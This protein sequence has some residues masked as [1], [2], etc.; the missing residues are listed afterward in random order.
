MATAKERRNLRVVVNALA[1]FVVAIA[2]K[3]IKEGVCVGSELDFDFF[4]ILFAASRLEYSQDAMV[5][6]LNQS[7]AIVELGEESEVEF[8]IGFRYGYFY[9][10]TGN[11]RYPVL[12][13]GTPS[14]EPNQEYS[15]RYK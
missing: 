8:F 4:E 7:P 2:D 14:S 6:Y 15:S 9:A 1:A 3:S 10:G 11:D 5:D 12:M 13:I